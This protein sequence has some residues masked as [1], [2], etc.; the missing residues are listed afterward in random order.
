MASEVGSGTLAGSGIAVIV[1]LS[2]VKEIGNPK[3]SLRSVN[4]PRE[5][6]TSV[7]KDTVLDKS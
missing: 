3:G 2:D 6:V 5:T 1:P 4:G 7:P